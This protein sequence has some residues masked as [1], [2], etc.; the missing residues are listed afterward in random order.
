MENN[1]LLINYDRWAKLYWKKQLEGN[2]TNEEEKELKELEK[3]N[4]ESINEFYN[5]LKEDK[6]IQEWIEKI[7]S[8]EWIKVIDGET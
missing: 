1:F 6:E 7:K 4:M 5:A 8:H 2:L 3:K